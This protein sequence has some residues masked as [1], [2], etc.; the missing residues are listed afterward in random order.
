MPVEPEIKRAVSFIGGQNLFRHTKD[1]FG[2][3]HPIK[4]ADAVC[5]ASGWVNRGVRFYT[6]VPSQSR[7]AM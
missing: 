1:A 5:V 2:H 6:G 7:S 4:L 3:H